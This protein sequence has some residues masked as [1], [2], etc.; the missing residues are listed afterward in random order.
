MGVNT[1]AIGRPF[2]P[3]VTYFLAHQSEYEPRFRLTDR[4]RG[5]PR[6]ETSRNKE[7][8]YSPHSSCPTGLFPVHR[9]TLGC[10]CENQWAGSTAVLRVRNAETRSERRREVR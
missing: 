7:A 10:G 1:Q 9:R 2:N 6:A 8:D 3:H 5:P 4:D